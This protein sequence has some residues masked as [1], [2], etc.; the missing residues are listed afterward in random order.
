MRK[1][2][3]T[4]FV[5][6]AMLVFATS[7]LALEKTAMRTTEVDGWSSAGT[8]TCSIQ[9]WNS[10][11]GWVWTWS[12]WSPNDFIG[13][14]YESCCGG[15]GTVNSMDIFTTTGAPAGYGFTGL[16]ETYAAD[17]NCCPT[18]A[19]TA[20]VPTLFEPPTQI[21]NYPLGGSVGSSF[22]VTFTHGPG[23]S[24]P[25]R[26]VTDFAAAGPTGPQACGTCYPTTRV[27]N[28]YYYGTPTSL[29]CPGT[30]LNDGT[31]DVEFRWTANLTCG[32]VSVEDETWGGIKNLYR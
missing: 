3:M 26:H 22:V 29:L 16:L 21:G 23:G 11:V 24:G 1:F 32:P 2:F 8:S 5:L 15:G 27:S 4:A 12:G 9:Y 13:V 19:P 18:G 17:G 31:C 14:C 25:F 10:C 7:G 30:K 20:S 28:S 6:G